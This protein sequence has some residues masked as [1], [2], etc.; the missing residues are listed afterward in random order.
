MSTNPIDLPGLLFPLSEIHSR[1]RNAK[2]GADAW[3]SACALLDAALAVHVGVCFWHAKE[4]APAA[5]RDAFSDLLRPSAARLVNALGTLARAL[6]DSPAEDMTIR[7]LYGCLLSPAVSPGFAALFSAANREDLASQ[8]QT[9]LGVLDGLV[10][11]RETAG[12]ALGDQLHSCALLFAQ[13]VSRATNQLAIVPGA[14]V[15]LAEGWRDPVSAEQSVRPVSL[16]SGIAHAADVPGIAAGEVYLEKD[17]LIHGVTPLCVG[18]YDEM[19]NRCLAYLAIPSAAR[20]LKLAYFDPLA[21]RTIV[22]PDALSFLVASLSP[23]LR[24]GVKTLNAAEL[25]QHEATRLGS[26]SARKVLPAAETI[27]GMEVIR[28]IGQGGMADVY[29]AWQPGLGRM[30]A[31]KVLPADVSR[32]PIAVARF[33]A[34]VVALGMVQHPNLVAVYATGQERGPSGQHRHYYAMEYIKGMDF[35]RLV[36]ALMKQHK[37]PANTLTSSSVE[38]SLAAAEQPLVETPSAVEGPLRADGSYYARIARLVAQAARGVQH[39]HERGIVHRD[40]KPAN[41]M[42]ALEDGRA[43]VMDLGLARLWNSDLSLGTRSLLVLGT[44]RYMAPEQIGAGAHTVTP[45]ADVYSLGATLFELATL[46]PFVE[47]PTLAQLQFEIVHGKS[48]EPR[49]ANSSI[50]AGLATI[51]ETAIAKPPY[52]RFE[53]AGQFADLLEAFAAGQ[54]I[55]PRPRSKI[56]AS[57]PAY[58]DKPAIEVTLEDYRAI[59]L[60]ISKATSDEDAFRTRLAYTGMRHAKK[61]NRA[62]ELRLEALRQERLLAPHLRAIMGAKTSEEAAKARSSVKGPYDLNSLDLALA[63]TLR[64]LRKDPEV[65]NSLGMSFKLISAG[66]FEMGDEEMSHNPLHWVDLSSDFYVGTHLVTNSQFRAFRSG[67]DSGEVQGFTLDGEDQP[68][69]FVSW[70]EAEAFC[71]WLSEREGRV[72]RLPTEAEWEYCARCGRSNADSKYPWMNGGP[73][74]PQAGVWPPSGPAGNFADLT[75]FR[76]IGGARPHGFDYDDGFVV[77]SPVGSFP[78]NLWGLFDM[79]GNAWEWCS[80]WYD[81]MYCMKNAV[82]PK[83]PPDSTIGLCRVARGC[84]TYRN[85]DRKA[86]MTGM[87]GI[88]DGYPGW[89]NVGLRVVLEVPR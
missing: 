11:L 19:G 49:L 21:G 57:L 59:A 75:S 58:F 61:L 83:G 63:E 9:N 44:V 36:V 8:A 15:L 62:V 86:L 68:A 53:S 87:R 12:E 23:E 78:P 37:D 17:G 45:A 66:R 10:A 64:F 55:P 70:Y 30:V 72:Y 22:E 73:E 88:M 1:V 82:D 28:K 6:A 39:L 50:P 67:H 4:L 43:V 34:E 80:D 81:P 46:K 20:S 47:A 40:I 5:A 74:Q 84:G 51:I 60:A 24:D 26:P 65:K 71:K 38:S 32:N 79:C 33:K 42:L 48:P 54:A 76:A 52:E 27:G 25:L 77:T 14:Q 56:L 89:D 31:L 7:S 35:G 41:I 2:T 16:E 85:C 3:A 29:Q 13:A 69:V 18:F